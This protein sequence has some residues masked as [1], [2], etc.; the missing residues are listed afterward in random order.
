MKTPAKI[1]LLTLFAGGAL[2]ACQ[3]EKS[4][5]LNSEQALF[6]KASSIQEMTTP[7]APAVT[8]D[9]S[10]TKDSNNITALEENPSL[11][12]N[13]EAL[14]NQPVSSAL[15]DEAKA[16]QW[17]HSKSLNEP[18]GV[19]P[20]PGFIV[21]TDQLELGTAEPIDLENSK[22]ESV[23][24]LIA[25]N[26]PADNIDKFLA[27]QRGEH[28]DSAGIEEASEKFTIQAAA[29]P[30]SQPHKG[31]PGGLTASTLK[32]FQCRTAKKDLQN[33]SINILGYRVNELGVH[34]LC[35]ISKNHPNGEGIVMAYAK[36]ERRFCDSYV[37]KYMEEIKDKDNYECEAVIHLQPSVLT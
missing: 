3:S 32:I 9:S 5:R 29:L 4:K 6:K 13:E 19:Q 22:P 8:E 30:V 25:L 2:T 20:P 31:S 21:K 37:V 17:V 35:E 15:S 34:P 7:D 23:E 36:Y 10:S 1:I 12:T 26:P 18:L 28:Q 33:F 16:E 24:D 14:N 27:Q 11:K